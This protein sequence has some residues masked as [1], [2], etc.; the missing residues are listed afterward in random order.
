MTLTREEVEHIARLAR[1]GV[2]EADIEKFRDQ[3]SVILE[4]F[5]TLRQIDTEGVEATTYTLPIHNVMSRDAV[6]PSS[7]IEKVL[8]NAPQTEGEL[9]RVRAVLESEP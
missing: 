6:Q 5:D 7:P 4:H 3:L 2:S 1:L 9:I 8:K